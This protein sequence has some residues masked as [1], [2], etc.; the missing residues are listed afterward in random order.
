M[1]VAALALVAAAKG[2]PRGG[3]PAARRGKRGGLYNGPRAG[4]DGAE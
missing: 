1:I 2:P 4:I 3:T